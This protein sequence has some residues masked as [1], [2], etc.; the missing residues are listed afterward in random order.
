MTALILTPPGWTIGGNGRLAVRAGLNVLEDEG[1][2]L[3]VKRI[4]AALGL[5][6][7]FKASFDKAN[8]S[9]IK[10]YRGLGLEAGLK[11]LARLKIQLAVPVVTDLHD[12]LQAAYRRRRRHSPNASLP[13]ASH[14]Y[15]HRDSESRSEGTSTDPG[16]EAPVHAP[17]GTQK[18][19]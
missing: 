4:C 13:G 3:D 15:S 7:V 10:S 11:I 2:A 1:L 17:L 14:G 6:Y 19:S 16:R 5:P 12:P 8:R 18:T 9:Y